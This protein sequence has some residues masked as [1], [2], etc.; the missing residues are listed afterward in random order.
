MQYYLH[1]WK[2]NSIFAP[3]LGIVPSMIFKYLRVMN[4]EC[5]FKVSAGD[6]IYRVEE[7][8]TSAGKLFYVVMN[9]RK[10]VEYPC[11]YDSVWAATL[12]AHE[13]AI[14]SLHIIM[15]RRK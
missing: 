14:A 12:R 1:I 7:R 2:K 6:D 15:N 11:V 8:R 5:F 4:K 13:C 10:M 3:D 9:R